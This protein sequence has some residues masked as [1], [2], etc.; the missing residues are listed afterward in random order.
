MILFPEKD[1]YPLCINRTDEI[2]IRKTIKVFAQYY[3][4]LV[5]PE[6]PMVHLLLQVHRFQ[7]LHLTSGPKIINKLK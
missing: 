6:V 4:H 3:L 1:N 5:K 7:I 2:H